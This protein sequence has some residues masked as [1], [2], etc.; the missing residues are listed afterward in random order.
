MN[1]VFK[2]EGNLIRDAQTSLAAKSPTI[3][4]ALH[5]VSG[6]TERPKYS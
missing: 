5:K 2:G 1:S 6:Q 3:K 4:I